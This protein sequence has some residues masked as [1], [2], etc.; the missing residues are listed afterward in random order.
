MPK[1]QQPVK[2]TITS[3]T[4]LKVLAVVLVLLFLYAIR[5][6]IVL[7]LLSM[8]LAAALDPWV[9]W[10]QKKRLATWRRN[11]VDLFGIGECIFTLRLFW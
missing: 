5:D 11:S 4:I 6:I 9:D 3:M 10:L 1:K 7:I 8:V 2:V